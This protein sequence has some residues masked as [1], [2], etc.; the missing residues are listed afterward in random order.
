MLIDAHAHIHD[1]KN[2]SEMKNLLSGAFSRGV[3]RIFCNS[4]RFEDWQKIALLSK[5]NQIIPFYGLHPWCVASA[6]NNWLKILSGYLSKHPNCGVGE[7]G[8]DKSA[9][10]AAFN[11]QLAIFTSQ[12]DL[13]IETRKPVT[14]HCLKA[15]PELIHALQARAPRLPKIMLHSFSG[16][17]PALRELLRLGAF[18]SFSSK[19]LFKN[20]PITLSLFLATPKE[21]LLLET[22]FAS[23]RVPEENGYF[24]CIDAIYT[25]SAGIL[26]I[27]RARL[28]EIIWKNGTL[29]TH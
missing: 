24:N 21:R 13:A 28:E 17:Q 18:I 9:R 11:L 29:L 10:A 22:D 27:E 14:I 4:A 16:P 8:L 6:P 20:D 26:G 25:K 7:I 5:N 23:S 1:I 15:W 19:Q 2:K 12:L 3:R